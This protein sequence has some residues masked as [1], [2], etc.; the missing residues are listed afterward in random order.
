MGQTNVAIWVAYCSRP[1]VTT[2][3]CPSRV[4]EGLMLKHFVKSVRAVGMAMSRRAVVKYKL[5]KETV[6]IVRRIIYN[7]I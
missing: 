6:S 4:S 5:G 2:E 3:F 7:Y 1:F